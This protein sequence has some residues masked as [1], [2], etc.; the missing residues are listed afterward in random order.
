MLA[1]D[2][3]LLPELFNDG[4]VTSPH[5]V[6]YISAHGEQ[7][8]DGFRL[9]LHRDHWLPALGG[10][11]GATAPRIVAFDAC[12][13]IAGDGWRT[14]WSAAHRPSLRLVLG[15]ASPATVGRAQ[16]ER[17][18]AFARLMAEGEPVVTSWLVAVRRHAGHDRDVPVALAFAIDDDEARFL[19]DEAT[20]SDVLDL[21]ALPSAVTPARRP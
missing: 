7:S 11:D 16:G 14:S 13:L 15:F 9:I 17:G 18:R 19:L 6:L 8:R 1:L 4:A 5:D 10:L 12:Q 2:E 3:W 21:P 20:L